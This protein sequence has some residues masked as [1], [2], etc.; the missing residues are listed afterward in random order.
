M[1]KVLEVLG[2]GFQ[3]LQF[4]NYPPFQLLQ[5]V[6]DFAFWGRQVT[7]FGS[8]S[9]FQNLVDLGNPLQGFG[10]HGPQTQFGHAELA[11]FHLEQ[12]RHLLLAKSERKPKFFQT[13]V[14]NV[15]H[16]SCKY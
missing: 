9:A 15:W 2:A 5:T 16:V 4:P 1:P 14:K 7:G 6:Q 13:E 11:P 10:F 8:E 3:L 12:T